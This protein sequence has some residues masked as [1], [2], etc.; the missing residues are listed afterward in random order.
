MSLASG[1]ARRIRLAIK[2][3]RNVAQ[4]TFLLAFEAPSLADAVQPGQFLMVSLPELTDP[5]LPR[6]FAVFNVKQGCVEVLYKRVGKGTH[7]LSLL[8]SGDFIHVLGPLGNGYTLSPSLAPCLVL[9]GGIGIASVHLLLRGLLDRGLATTL[10][11]GAASSKELIPLDT[12]KDR[13]L[14][15]HLATEDGEQGFK[16]NVCELFRSLLDQDRNLAD[17][18]RCVY[19]CGSPAM[20]KA[21]AAMLK[22]QGLKGQFSLESRMACGYG[23]CQGCVIQTRNHKMD[24]GSHYGKVCTEGP[25]FDPQEVVWESVS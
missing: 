23:V 17:S 11:Y 10:L 20:L 2:N 19:V 15:I 4:D 24:T 6:P 22:P 8:R 18:L 21:A 1:S 7:L 12:V 3:N 25:V 9:A 16:G 14:E 13:P 5:L